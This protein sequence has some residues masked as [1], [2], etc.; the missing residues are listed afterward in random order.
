MRG[1]R[2]PTA[3]YREFTK[4]CYLGDNSIGLIGRGA[5][6]AMPY[7][8]VG[9]VLR[10]VDI[11]MEEASQAVPP[12]STPQQ[13]AVNR[14]SGAKLIN[15]IGDPTPPSNGQGVLLLR[16]GYCGRTGQRH[17]ES[18]VRVAAL[19]LTLCLVAGCASMATTDPIEHG[20]HAAAAHG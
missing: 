6:D 10:W 13:R 3:A 19:L 2:G 8:R 4:Y 11:D 17:R 5:K 14:T 15:S 7:L 9:S 12:G 1:E 20:L 16:R 18:L